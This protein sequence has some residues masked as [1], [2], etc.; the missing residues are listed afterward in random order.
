MDQEKQV[1][2]PINRYRR[3]SMVVGLRSLEKDVCD[4]LDGDLYRDRVTKVSR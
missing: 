2:G 4:V 3:S 1:W